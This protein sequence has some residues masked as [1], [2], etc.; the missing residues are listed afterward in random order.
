M[1]CALNE[2]EIAMKLKKLIKEFPDF[3]VKGTKDVEITGICAD[4]KTVRPGNLF[5][6][7]RGGATHGAKYIPEAIEGGAVAVLTDMY[8]PMFS[9]VTQLIHPNP[10]FVE[11]HLAEVFHNYPSRSL[12][13]VGITG[14][15]G[16]TTV[17]YLVRALLNSIRGPCGLIGTIEYSVGTHSL[18]ATRTTPEVTKN[19]KLLHEMVLRGCRSAV[20]E[21]SSHAL[22][23]GRVNTIEFDAAI[24]T[25]FSQDHLDYHQSME[26]YCEAK[27]RL[28][29]SMKESSDKKIGAFKVAIVNRDDPWTDRIIA[30]CSVEVMTYGID[31]PADVTAENLIFEQ[32]STQFELCCRGERVLCTSPLIGRFNVYNVLAAAALAIANGI[33]LRSLPEKIRA[34]PFVPG[35]LEPVVNSIGLRVYV[36]FAHTDDALRNVLLTLRKMKPSRLITVFGCAGDRDKSKR[37]KMAKV[38]SELSDISIVTSDNPRSED[39]QTIIDEIVSAFPE[40]AVCEVFVDR[41]QAI[42]RALEMAQSSDI[43]LIAGKGHETKQIFARQTIEF[44]DKKVAEEICRTLR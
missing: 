14:T 1:K 35:R 4:S 6:A 10:S 43:V 31:N 37:P 25:N 32:N 2:K 24:F 40:G 19:N 23:Q 7:R 20:M 18:P 17:S 42:R 13:M 44:D 3:V 15:N 28:F 33:P 27:R 36:D 5:V 26:E 39:P 8:D 38:C 41:S 34:F 29:L 11:G 9:K 30:G 22:D 16:K 21:V 12:Y